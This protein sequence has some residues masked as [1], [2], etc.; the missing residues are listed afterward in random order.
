V[1]Y[2]DSN[3]VVGYSLVGGYDC[4]DLYEL[5]AEALA[6]SKQGDLYSTDSIVGFMDYLGCLYTL[7]VSRG[8]WKRAAQAMD[9]KYA[10]ASEAL[11]SS[12]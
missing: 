10:I 8:H 6:G 11:S 7:Y 4:L 9:A 2:S 5:A 1:A 12:S 3:E